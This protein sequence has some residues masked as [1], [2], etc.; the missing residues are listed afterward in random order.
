MKNKKKKYY[1]IAGVAVTALLIIFAIIKKSNKEYERVATESAASRNIIESI[2]ATGKIQPVTDVKISPY[3]SGEIIEIYIREGD[4]VKAG[5]LLV[6][7][8]PEIYKSAFEQAEAQLNSQKAGLANARAQLA[9][10]EARFRNVEIS[11]NRSKGLWEKKVISDADYETARM[12]YEVAKA[13]LEAARQSIVAS[14][15]SVNSSSAALRKTREDLTKTAVYAPADGRVSKLGVEKGE[16]VMGASQFSSGTELMRIANLENMQAVVDV[17]E[18][19]IVK[20]KMGDTAL[21]ELDAYLNRKFRGIVTEMATSATSSGVSIDQV[22]NFQVKVQIMK[23]SY[24]DLIPLDRPDY[25]PFRPGMSAT[26][27]IQTE[28][29]NDVLSVPIQAVT[30]RQ[31]TTGKYVRKKVE[32]DEET[33]EQVEENKRR[34]NTETYKEYVFVY[35]N[36]MVRLREVKSGIQDNNHIEIIS[37]LESGEEV[38]TAPFSAISKRL[39]NNDKVD[40]V[41]KEK[42]YEEK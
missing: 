34:T 3:I 2:S 25:S 30:T 29:R 4:R 19:D 41:D 26:V 11:Y 10:V 21:I 23:D 14:E 6:R 37:G 32:V 20:V 33:G 7:I 40:K 8:D 5:D 17:N 12:N 9:Q 22:T 36:G 16:R 24:I 27:D 42:L 13:D 38:V 18:N 35:D 28:R 39:K 15:F 1:I 31:D